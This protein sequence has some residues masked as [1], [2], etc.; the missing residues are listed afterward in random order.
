MIDPRTFSTVLFTGGV[1]GNAY[2]SHGTSN[3][4]GGS[5]IG[6]SSSCS[7]PSSF[8]EPVNKKDHVAQE[9]TE[10]PLEGDTVWTLGTRSVALASMGFDI[11]VPTNWR[12]GQ[13]TWS[14]P[15]VKLIFKMIVSV[16]R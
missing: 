9:H 13:K 15:P 2:S 11:Y 3:G 5:C 7:D 1:N 16:D 12:S 6:A 14:A 8:Y 4:I 10:H